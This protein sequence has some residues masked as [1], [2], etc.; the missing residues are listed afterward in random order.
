M[1]QSTFAKLAD[2]AYKTV[3][4]VLS[5][6]SDASPESA[7]KFE[8]ATSGEVPA[9]AFLEAGIN[10]VVD[11]YAEM[12]LD[13]ASRRLG[14]PKATVVKL[15]RDAL[16]KISGSIAGYSERGFLARRM[17]QHLDAPK[18]RNIHNDHATVNPKWNWDVVTE[19][20]SRR[21]CRVLMR[22]GKPV[23]EVE[24]KPTM[25]LDH[26]SKTWKAMNAANRKASAVEVEK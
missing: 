16:K 25:A 2:V 23:D 24:T 11:T 12:S 4:N 3:L 9:S 20:T 22:D 26:K 5:G 10:S 6:Q 21:S 7:V 13:E 8:V 18:K 15:E 14:I 1:S 19:M 17:M